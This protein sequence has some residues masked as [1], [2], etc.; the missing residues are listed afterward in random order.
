MYQGSASILSFLVAPQ[1][2]FCGFK[3]RKQ[4]G[5]RSVLPAQLSSWGCGKTALAAELIPL[6]AHSFQ[7]LQ[8]VTN[9]MRFCKL[10]IVNFLLQLWDK[11]HRLLLYLKATGRGAKAPCSSLSLR[12]Q[13]SQP[14]P[15]LLKA[16][17]PGQLP[18]SGTWLHFRNQSV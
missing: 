2:C 10:V 6:L 11:S 4:T 17:L 5:P 16:L 3:N 13:S 8:H 7:R 9:N 18:P 12:S 1:R 14:A 15:E